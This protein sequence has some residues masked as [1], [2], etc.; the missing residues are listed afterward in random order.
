MVQQSAIFNCFSTQVAEN[1]IRRLARLG[2]V[3]LTLSRSHLPLRDR[4]PQ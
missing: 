1:V 4:H 3:P 2:G